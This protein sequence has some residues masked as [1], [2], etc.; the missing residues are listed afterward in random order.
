MISLY[1]SVDNELVAIRLIH[2][3]NQY[4]SLLLVEQFHGVLP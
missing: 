3:L 1:I 2:S 4:L